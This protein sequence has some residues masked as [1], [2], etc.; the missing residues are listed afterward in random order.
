MIECRWMDRRRAHTSKSIFD[1]PEL[2]VPTGSTIAT[3]SSTTG[4]AVLP[5]IGG[6]LRLGGYPP[7]LMKL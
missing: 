7:V 3:G 5:G 4:R 1:L 6:K 2:V